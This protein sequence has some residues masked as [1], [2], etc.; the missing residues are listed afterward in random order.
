MN[1]R[2]VPLRLLSTLAER[3]VDIHGQSQH[4]SLFRVREHM[5]VLDQYGGL[6]QLRTQVAERVRQLMEVRRELDRLRTDEQELAQRVDVL[7]YQVGEIGA[8]NLRPAEDEDL[9]PS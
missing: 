4:L 1:G 9:I 8:A 5:D 2:I 7:R 6:W 3:L